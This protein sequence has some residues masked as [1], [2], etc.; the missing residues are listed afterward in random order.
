VSAEAMLPLRRSSRSASRDGPPVTASNYVATE[1]RAEILRG[2]FALGSRLDQQALAERFGVSIIPVREA[3]K[4][5]E[6]EGLVRMQPR[7]GAF[8]AQ[9]TLRE[10]TEISWIRE[11]LEELATRL[12]APRLTERNLRELDDI[13]AK[14]A[15]MAGRARPAVW[16]AL[17]REW[18]FK[19]YAAGE[20][21][22]LVQMIAVLWDRTSLYREVL[23]ASQGIRRGAQVQHGSVEQHAEMLRRL[24][25]GD[26]SGTTRLMRQHIRRAI[27][28]MHATE[29][30]ATAAR[31]D[32]ARS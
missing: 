23:A 25:S 20:S 22:L 32:G 21:E 18:H 14:M 24:R 11:R 10:L 31:R 27:R 26:V 7:R 3:L 15:R 16:A 5:L 4:R 28:D 2:S 8:V 17:N 6:V 13:N 9:L 29:A 19:L 30:G 1:I 12:A